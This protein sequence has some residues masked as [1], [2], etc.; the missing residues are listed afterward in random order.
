MQIA[1]LCGREISKTF[2]TFLQG[3]LNELHNQATADSNQQRGEIV[4]VVSGVDRKTNAVS[5]TKSA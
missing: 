2:E 5:L 1:R 4:I 3:T